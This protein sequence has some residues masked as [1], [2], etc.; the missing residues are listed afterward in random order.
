MTQRKLKLNFGDTCSPISRS[1]SH[2]P[3]EVNTYV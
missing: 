2:Q 1:D 3:K